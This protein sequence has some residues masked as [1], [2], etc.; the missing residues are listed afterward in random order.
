MESRDSV[1]DPS[2]ID[3]ILGSPFAVQL[4]AVSDSP[5]RLPATPPQ[6]AESAL[7]Q[8]LQSRLT[9]LGTLFLITGAIGLPLLWCSPVFTRLEKCLWS[10]ATTLYTAALVGVTWTIVAWCYRSAIGMIW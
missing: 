9:V 2:P 8:T 1:N 4:A 7:Q 5:G 10:M 6:P 3:P